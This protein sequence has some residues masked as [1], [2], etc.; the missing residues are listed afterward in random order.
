[1]SGTGTQLPSHNTA[2]QLRALLAPLG[3]YRWEDTFQWAEL[4][5]VGAALDACG[6]EL[7]EL[8]RECLLQTAET[9]GLDRLRSLLASSPPGQSAGQKRTALAALL[10]IGD[11]SFTPDA[12]RDNL[13]GCGLL[14]EVA[15]DSTPGGVTVSF[16]EVKGIPDNFAEM[17]VII[18]N[19][20]PA[21]AEIFYCYHYLTWGEWEEAAP[22][23]A[24]LESKAST[25]KLLEIMF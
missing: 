20:L 24:A 16:P 8:E 5:A 18:E 2:Q 11:G 10:R 14:V 21:H 13:S 22:T 25:W 1:M 9:W 12:I 4:R 19:I 6:A 23:W 17:R 15:E 3:V 7:E